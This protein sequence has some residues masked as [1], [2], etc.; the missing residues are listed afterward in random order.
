MNKWGTKQ[1]HTSAGTSHAQLRLLAGREIGWF[2][3]AMETDN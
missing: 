1:T 2:W 3:A